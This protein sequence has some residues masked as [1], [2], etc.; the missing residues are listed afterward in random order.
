LFQLHLAWQ[1]F[2]EAMGMMIGS[3]KVK[4][5][6]RV[7]RNTLRENIGLVPF[8]FDRTR[9][10]NRRQQRTPTEFFEETEVLSSIKKY[11]HN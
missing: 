6:Q 2:V 10:P 11:Y 9:I 3:E 1:L 5:R 4:T 7:A 8:K